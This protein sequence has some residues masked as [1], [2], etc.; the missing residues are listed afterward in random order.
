MQTL[1]TWARSHDPSAELQL[2]F[3][4]DP[5]EPS[6]ASW[7]RNILEGLQHFS[8]V[9]TLVECSVEGEASEAMTLRRL[10]NSQDQ[11]VWTKIQAKC[12]ELNPTATVCTPG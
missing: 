5:H 12:A 8:E 10:S 3:D 1:R 11:Q 7:Y 4:D 6:E 2:F 9:P